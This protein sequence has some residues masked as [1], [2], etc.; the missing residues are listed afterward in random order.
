MLTMSQRRTYE[1]IRQYISDNRFSPTVAEIAEGIGIKS[2][3]VVHR[4]LQALVSAG[5]I[6]LTPNRHRNIRLMDSANEAGGLPLVGKIAAGSPIEAI[7]QYESVDVANVF[8][9]PNRYALQV[10]GDSMIEDGIY[11]GDIV[12]CERASSADNG[13]IVVALIDQQEATLKR[14][15]RTPDGMITLMPANAKLKPMVYEPERV[16]IQ[17]IYVGLLRV[18]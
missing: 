17:G 16:T 6:T 9:G 18:G 5:V 7:E 11:D 15:M 4:Y 13:Q 3:G 1:F 8:L 12:V 14:L 10:E 2:R